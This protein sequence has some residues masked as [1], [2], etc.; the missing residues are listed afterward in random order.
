M[1]NGM[2]AICAEGKQMANLQQKIR[3]KAVLQ[4]LIY[5]VFSFC[6]F[7]KCEFPSVIKRHLIND[8]TL[9]NRKKCVMCASF[10]THIIIKI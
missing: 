3:L 4:K 8:S 5:S 9:K 6:W 1:Q 10:G 2:A 7:Q